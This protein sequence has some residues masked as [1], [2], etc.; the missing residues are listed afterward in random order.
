M[1]TPAYGTDELNVEHG[2]AS[3]RKS[4]AAGRRK[5]SA[6]VGDA[7]PSAVEASELSAA[8]RRLAELGY[9]Q[10]DHSFLVLLRSLL[11]TAFALSFVPGRFTH[12]EAVP[13]EIWISRLMTL[14]HL[15]LVFIR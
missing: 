4:S 8:D 15:L 7:P 11:N 10:V 3:R 1:S 14:Q 6:V 12:W 2:L 9:I 13:D 5:S